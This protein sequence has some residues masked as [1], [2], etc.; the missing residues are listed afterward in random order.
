M[1]LRIVR[2]KDAVDIMKSLSDGH[3][4]FRL[5]TMIALAVY[6][7]TLGLQIFRDHQATLET[8]M[9]RADNIAHVL[10]GQIANYL[11]F[12]DTTLES[13]E[14]LA[15]ILP[16]LSTNDVSMMTVQSLMVAKA[17]RL[18]MIRGFLIVGAD[19]TMIM[20]EK[21]RPTVPLDLSDRNY[22]QAWIEPR[23]DGVFV[24]EPIVGRTSGR[25][26][27][28]VSRR[29]GNADGSFG[30]VIAAIVEPTVLGETL[31]A[32][33]LG[34]RG[35]AALVANS[36]TIIARSS[37]HEANIGHGAGQDKD[38]EQ[39]GWASPAGPPSGI[40]VSVSNRIVTSAPVPGC[41]F[42]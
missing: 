6:N 3:V 23:T 12:V 39:A 13:I 18:D 40:G 27:L 24:G 33:D 25:W 10:T 34:Q 2:R 5:L 36:G 20:D 21:G 7:L 26:F 9:L 29:R 1:I 19:G 8:A 4:S 32:A 22:F 15:R 11:T 35:V 14:F 42:R 31:A 28:G 30:G 38:L 16:P 41:V 17:A 37:G